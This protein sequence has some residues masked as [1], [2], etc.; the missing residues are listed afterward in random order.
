M[1]TKYKFLN[2]FDE[3]NTELLSEIGYAKSMREYNRE[4][5]KKLQKK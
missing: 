3:V 2:K 1:I 4:I 5:I